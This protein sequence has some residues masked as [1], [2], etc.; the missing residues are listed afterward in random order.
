MKK[1]L[2]PLMILGLFSTSL[3]ALNGT[4]GEVRFDGVTESVSITI[5]KEDSTSTARLPLVA[6]TADMEKTLIAIVL[7]AKAGTLKVDAL[8]RT[9]GG[10]RGW[11][12][13]TLK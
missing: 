12:I 3:M 1:L 4:I 9:I 7:T 2:L 6:Q 10:I 13:I 5:I 8:V 11:G